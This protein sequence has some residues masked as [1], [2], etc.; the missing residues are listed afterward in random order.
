MNR[1]AQ[2]VMMNAPGEAGPKQLKELHLQVKLPKSKEKAQAKENWQR[3]PIR[4]G[5]TMEIELF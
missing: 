4:G 3:R 1:K 5:C 2:D